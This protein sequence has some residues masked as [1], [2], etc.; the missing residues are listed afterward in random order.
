MPVIKSAMKRVKTNAK[1]NRRNVAQRSATK[2]T[3]KKFLKAKQSGSKGLKN[4]FR[5][6]IGAIDRA[7]SKGLIKANKAKRNK[8]HLAKMLN[9]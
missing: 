5:V 4:S 7:K 2:S 8:S 1:A 3:I 6:A 9:K